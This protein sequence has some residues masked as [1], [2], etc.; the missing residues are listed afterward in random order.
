LARALELIRG[1]R[2]ALKVETEVVC[3]WVAVVTRDDV[4]RLAKAVD[5]GLLAIADVAVRAVRGAGT[6]A[7]AA[8]YAELIAVAGVAVVAAV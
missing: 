6:A 3:A 2:A 4:D 5:A 7:A 8:V 1:V